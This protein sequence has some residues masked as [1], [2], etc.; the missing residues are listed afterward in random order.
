MTAKHTRVL[1]AKEI[2]LGFLYI[3]S[4]IRKRFPKGNA[5]VPIFIGDEKSD[6]P[7]HY[8][9]TYHR[10]FGLTRWYK[11]IEARPRQEI[12]IEDLADGSFKIQIVIGATEA[13]YTSEEAKEII[14]LSG[15]SSTAKGNIIEDRIKE[16]ILVMGQGSLSVYRPVSDTE[17]I[18]LIVL[19]RGVFQPI[20][21][22]VKG[23]FGL[24]KGGTFL[25]DIRIKT[26]R[27]HHTYFVVG[28]YFDPATLELHDSLVLVP[29]NVVASQGQVV[30]AKG[31]ERYRIITRLSDK[32][33]GK[34]AE[35]VCKKQDLAS[36]L[37]EKFE[38]IERYLR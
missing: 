6:Q 16:Q 12:E 1:I 25:C 15:L 5:S 33:H 3:P 26:F 17:A 18:D 28:A 10:L 35:F 20:F 27:P 2:E 11:Q 37:L 14:D 7:L 36:R 30:K 24:R 13:E 4:A 32:G 22:Q 31:G 38:E 9:A 34:W 19:K 8:N 23:C 21:L 29:S